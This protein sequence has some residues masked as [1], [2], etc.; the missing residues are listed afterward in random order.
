M[1]FVGDDNF[2]ANVA[3][4]TDFNGDNILDLG[5]TADQSSIAGE[6]RGALYLL[7]LQPDGTVLSHRTISDIHGGF[8]AWHQDNDRFGNDKAPMKNTFDLP[9]PSLFSFS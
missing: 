4:F 9:F 3:S 6:V 5:V 8:T 2:G 7:F 1:E